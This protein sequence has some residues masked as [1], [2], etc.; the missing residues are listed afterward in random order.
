M[1]V[2]KTTQ[3]RVVTHC[4]I[5]MTPK[6]AAA[7]LTPAEVQQARD[8]AA[9][10]NL[11][12]CEVKP[13]TNA[14]NCIGFAFARSHG[15][16][17]EHVI[18]CLD[19]CEVASFLT[20]A[21]GDIVTYTRSCALIHVGVVIRVTNG[22]IA[23]VRSKWSNWA[24]FSHGLNDVPPQ[25]GRP[26]TLL[27]P[28]L[29]VVPISDLLLE[30]KLLE[31]EKWPQQ[32]GGGL[33]PASGGAE[34]MPEFDGTEEAIRWALERISDPH[35]YR[36]AGLASTPEAARVI[37]ADLPG[38]KELI[39]AG[40]AAAADVLRYWR[41]A[42]ERQ[43]RN[44]LAVAL[45]LLQRIP[46]KEAVQPLARAISEGEVNGLNIYLAA[47]ALLTSADIEAVNESPVS[48]ALREA[49]RLK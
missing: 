24:E 47:D 39:E 46:T 20:P 28:R 21:E 17:N 34:E 19:D 1:G 3:M 36:L 31:E 43:D 48:V 6:C 41:G 12:A 7:E 42:R 27:R 5:G 11:D 15:W 25:F 23:R 8:E 4:H 30:E 45:Y 32:S 44:Q 35:V 29:G 14:Y 9:R 26:T 18:F 16:F 40:Q 10:F 37:I 49:E 13:P 22:Q 2:F 33:P 38:V